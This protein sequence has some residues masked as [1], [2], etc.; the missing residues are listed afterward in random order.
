MNFVNDILKSESGN[1][2]FTNYKLFPGFELKFLVF[3]IFW[4]NSRYFPS[5]EKYMTKLQFF[6]VCQVEWELWKQ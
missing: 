3:P 6:Q 1:I 5:L 2:K 4:T